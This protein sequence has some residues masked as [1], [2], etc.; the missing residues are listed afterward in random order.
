MERPNQFFR[1][2]YSSPS[3]LW[4]VGAGILFIVLALIL[5]FAPSLAYGIKEKTKDLFSFL[6]LLYGF[7]RLSTFY[8]EYNRKD[9]E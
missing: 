6:L 2:L 3:L 4:K 8:V 7:F 5:F 9:D 1:K